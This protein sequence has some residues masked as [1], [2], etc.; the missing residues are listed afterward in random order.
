MFM[1][2]TKYHTCSFSKYFKSTYHVKNTLSCARV[3]K[4]QTY[5]SPALKDI[6]V[7]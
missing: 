7:Y 1:I 5:K 6:S 3:T 4:M 2:D